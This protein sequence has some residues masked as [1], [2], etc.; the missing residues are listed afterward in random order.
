MPEN[1]FETQ[2]DLTKKTKL[3]EFYES[4]K[5]LIYSS[6]LSVIIIIASY[7][8]PINMRLIYYVMFLSVL[9]TFLTGLDYLNYYLK[10]LKYKR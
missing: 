1:L 9:I 3:R 5:I 7:Y 4:K 6:V 2:Y 10:Q 8:Y